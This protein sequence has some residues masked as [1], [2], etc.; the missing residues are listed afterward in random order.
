[1]LQSTTEPSIVSHRVV[2]S[3]I[4]NNKYKKS[5]AKIR[6]EFTWL[7]GKAGQRIIISSCLTFAFRVSS[8]LWAC[9]RRDHDEDDASNISHYNNCSFVTDNNQKTNYFIHNPL[10]LLLF[11]FCCV[12]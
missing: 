11:L 5:K 2:L 8:K 7:E 12:L 9:H 4:I 3:S 10:L 6:V 1:M